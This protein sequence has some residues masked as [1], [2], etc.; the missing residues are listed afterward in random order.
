LAV[1]DQDLQQAYNN[2]QQAVAAAAAADKAYQDVLAL[3]LGQERVTKEAGA[4]AAATAAHQAANAAD[5]QYSRVSAGYRLDNKGKTPTTAEQTAATRL[6]EEQGERDK[7]EKDPEVAARVT[8][9]Q[10]EAIR[11]RRRK[12]QQAN[13]PKP[14]TT[15]NAAQTLTAETGAA[16]AGEEARH[17]R[18]GESQAAM[19]EQQQAMQT[20][21]HEG[22]V[23]A[24]QV[25][26]GEIANLQA[27]TAA[28]ENMRQAAQGLVGAQVTMRG[29]DQNHIQARASFFSS[30]FNAIMTHAMT[31]MHGLP[32]G[33]QVANNYVKAALAMM[34][35]LYHRAGLDKELPNLDPNSPE[36][37]AL[38]I[39][40]GQAKPGMPQPTMPSAE[41]MA[42]KTVI[43]QAINGNPPPN[44]NGPIG[45]DAIPLLQHLDEARATQGLPPT[46]YNGPIPDDS[47]PPASATTGTKPAQPTTG[48]TAPATTTTPAAPGTQPDINKQRQDAMNTDAGKAITNALWSPAM[49]ALLNKEQSTPNLLTADEKQRL[50]DTKKAHTAAIDGLI[51]ANPPAP[52]TAPA[53]PTTGA[54]PT[55]TTPT[56]TAPVTP[57]KTPEQEQVAKANAL[58]YD[59]MMR[60]EESKRQK[61]GLDTTTPDIQTDI[62]NTA[63][64]RLQNGE[65]PAVTSYN[66]TEDAGLGALSTWRLAPETKGDTTGTIPKLGEVPE[67]SKPIDTTPSETGI[68]LGEIPKL[69]PIDNQVQMPTTSGVGGLTPGEVPYNFD[70]FKNQPITVP[71]T[72][73]VPMPEA[74]PVMLDTGPTYDNHYPTGD[75]GFSV[76]DWMNTN[77]TPQMPTPFVPPQAPDY[78][79]LIETP[80]IDMP[81]SFDSLSNANNESND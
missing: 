12:Q 41:Y 39:I 11:D 50:A 16:R 24:N 48:T 69:T 72:S 42:T 47:K 51:K 53:A 65:L 13:Q 64:Q 9:A 17:N 29:Q 4:K 76:P 36:V 43:M 26:Q 27:Q 8:D 44:Y 60:E 63:I 80:I 1:T 70:P 71:D 57:T 78:S 62:H 14:P 30:T 46:G 18:V 38:R 31:M 35:E 37:R 15:P 10:A 52:T 55:A 68:A 22:N 58:S 74:H 67:P 56:S 54:A 28:Q 61:A 81:V 5:R 23:T 34:N 25:Q 40:S 59:A 45:T 20:A 6:A 3:P 73:G 7:N 66:N 21:V 79:S 19:N 2:W 33:S 49:Q 75:L 77:T 32:K